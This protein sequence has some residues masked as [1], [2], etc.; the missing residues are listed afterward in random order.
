M[1]PKKIAAATEMVA[2]PA[3][4][5]VP[6]R[7]LLYRSGTGWRNAPAAFVCRVVWRNVTGRTCVAPLA[8]KRVFFFEKKEAKNFCFLSWMLGQ[9]SPQ[10]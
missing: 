4:K 5:V 2:A 6:R 1:W 9:G 8:M 7:P 3:T 10:N